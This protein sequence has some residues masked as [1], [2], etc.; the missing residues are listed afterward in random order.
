MLGRAKKSSRRT[1]SGVWVKEREPKL[2]H[3]P[4]DT[5]KSW[6]PTSPSGRLQM[7]TVAQ[8]H[9]SFELCCNSYR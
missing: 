7:D 6:L 5:G 4:G 2:F 8:H 9:P 1:A 3:Y